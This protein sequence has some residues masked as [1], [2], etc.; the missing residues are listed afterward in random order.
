MGTH[1][2]WRKSRRNISRCTSTITGKDL[3]KSRNDADILYLLPSMY[4]K[5]HCKHYQ[6]QHLCPCE[7][8]Q[9]YTEMRRFQLPKKTT[10]WTLIFK[11]MKFHAHFWFYSQLVLMVAFLFLLHSASLQGVSVS[12]A[13]EKVPTQKERVTTVRTILTWL[14][15]L[16]SWLLPIFSF[17]LSITL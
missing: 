3:H 1:P 12:S 14:R 16:F 5:A 2:A 4:L 10:D 13:K 15:K 9:K 8:Y 6:I 11:Y 7:K 17:Q